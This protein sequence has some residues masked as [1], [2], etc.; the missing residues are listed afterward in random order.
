M[1]VAVGSDTPLRHAKSLEDRGNILG[2]LGIILE[3][4][5]F[6]GRMLSADAFGFLGVVL[7]GEGCPTFV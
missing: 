6:M 1:S 3:G 5:C 7:E 2:T 4:E